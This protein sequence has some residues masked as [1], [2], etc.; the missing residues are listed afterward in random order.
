M[1]AL[2]DE[3]GQA[4]VI[5]VFALGIVAVVIGGLLAAQDRVLDRETQRRAGEAAVEAA[6]AVIADAYLA[7]LRRV[8]ASVAS[9]R[10]TPDVAAVI[11]SGVAREAARVAASSIATVNGGTSIDEVSVRCERSLVEVTL[12]TSG[13]SFRAGFAVEGCSPR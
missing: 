3:R 2:S 8:A 7:E 10:P 6:T 11:S 13:S 1:D 4:L 5:A 9:P 12:W